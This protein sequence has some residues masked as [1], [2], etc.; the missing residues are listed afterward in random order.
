VLQQLQVQGWFLI[1]AWGAA[2]CL[3]CLGCGAGIELTPVRG[4]I[5]RDGK[6]LSGGSILFSSRDG[7]KPVAGEIQSD[8]TFVLTSLSAG[9][10]ASPGRYLVSIVSELML[11]GRKMEVACI[12]P[13]DFLLTVESGQENEFVINIREADGWKLAVD[14]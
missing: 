4:V 7:H 14:D 1:A 11:R 5:Q 6:P 8:G 9:N 10:G 2:A 12:A 13:K 3:T